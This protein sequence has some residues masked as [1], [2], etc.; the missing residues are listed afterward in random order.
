MTL[1]RSKV[2]D[3]S[4]PVVTDDTTGFLSFGVGKDHGILIRAFGWRVWLA[5]VIIT[6]LYIAILGLSDWLYGGQTNWWSYIEFCLRS[7]C[8]DS[9]KI[10]Q[11]Q[12]YN[13]VYS[14]TWIWMSFVLFIAY[15]GKSAIEIGRF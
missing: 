5:V 9:V 14:S 3:F 4:L 12:A 10:P 1:L 11:S 15:E 13:K 7:M 8:M 6:P 2:V